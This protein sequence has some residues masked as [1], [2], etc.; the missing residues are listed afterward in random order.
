MVV[1]RILSASHLCHNKGGKDSVC[2]A[3]MQ[4]KMH[5]LPLYSTKSISIKPFQIIFSDVWTSSIRSPSGYKYFVS[6]ID[7]YSRFVWLV[8]LKLKFEVHQTFV[9]FNQL[10]KLHFQSSIQSLHSD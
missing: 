3:C 2:D 5:K 8:P 7:D 6:F 4:A 1:D 9:E 10:V